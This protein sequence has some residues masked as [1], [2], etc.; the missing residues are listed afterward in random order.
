MSKEHSAAIAAAEATAQ[1]KEAAEAIAHQRFAAVRD[2]IEAGE[3]EGDVTQ[4]DEFVQ[5][6][7]SRRETDEAWG[8]WAMAM[9]ARD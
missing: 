7:A 8:K 1:H 3:R 4:T 9:D 5:W 6:M 2:Q